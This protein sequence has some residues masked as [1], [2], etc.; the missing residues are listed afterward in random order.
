MNALQTAAKSFGPSAVLRVG[1][2][3]I[4]V[5]TNLLQVID[6]QTFIANGIDP[7]TKDTV[8]LKSMQHF[9]AA[10]EPI[11]AQVIVADSGA[12]ASPDHTGLPYTKVPR[13]I[14]PLDEGAGPG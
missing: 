3:D 8:A 9:R 5:A 2:V 13:P 12:L 11:A 4:L 7:R 10:F 1:G 6:L 14:W